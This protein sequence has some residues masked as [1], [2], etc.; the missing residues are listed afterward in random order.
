MLRESREGFLDTA[1]TVS[2]QLRELGLGQIAVVVQK[3]AET[4][5]FGDD[6]LG[7]LGDPLVV[8]CPQ[9][10]PHVL[11][12]G[13]GEHAGSLCALQSG[14]AFGCAVDVG[15]ETCADRLL[16]HEPGADD[17]RMARARGSR[18]VPS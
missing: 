9:D 5:T 10:R 1:T 14:D 16:G 6:L 2:T 3:P 15:A 13:H 18:G 8:Q 4:R 11:V 12:V 17:P 7:G